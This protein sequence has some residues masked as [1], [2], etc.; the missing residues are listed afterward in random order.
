MKLTLKWRLVVPLN[1]VTKYYKIKQQ[2]RQTEMVNNTNTVAL[3]L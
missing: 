2:S 1:L 3:W